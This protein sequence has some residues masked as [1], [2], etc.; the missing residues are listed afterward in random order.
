MRFDAKVEVLCD[1]CGHVEYWEPQFVY[2]NYAGG[3][4]HYDTSDGAFEDWLEDEGWEEF[5]EDQHRCDGCIV[6][7]AK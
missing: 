7:N 4:G 6:N 2:M 5:S 3:G 1:E